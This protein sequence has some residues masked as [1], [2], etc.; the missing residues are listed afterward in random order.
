MIHSGGSILPQHRNL[1]KMERT[2]HNNNNNLNISSQTPH[3]FVP[4][5]NLNRKQQQMI[6]DDRYHLGD[7]LGRGAFGRVFKAMDMKEGIMVAVKEIS[8]IGV[9][10][11]GSNNV[12]GEIELLKNL[13]HKNIVKYYKTIQKGDHL[14]IILEYME[15][16][17]LAALIEPKN[18]GVFPE[19]LV[20]VYIAQVLEGL[21]YLHSQGV[22][23][24]DIKGAN[25]LTT[26]EVIPFI[27]N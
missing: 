23:H 13:N 20:A 17:S 26:K 3:S 4:T 12:I 8:L 9:S 25:I 7:E 18:F 5:K 6:L 10:K 15:S 1:I 27:L 21:K 11:E 19:N 16:G 2:T 24:R 14:Y 22:V